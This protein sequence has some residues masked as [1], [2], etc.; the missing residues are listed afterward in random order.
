MLYAYFLY[1]FYY[2]WSIKKQQALHYS[3]N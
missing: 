1:K 3:N 2:T